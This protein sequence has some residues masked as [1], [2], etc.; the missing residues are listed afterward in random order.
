VAATSRTSAKPARLGSTEARVF[1]APAGELTRESSL[2]FEVVDFA[3]Q[4]LEIELYPWQ[5]WLLVHAL[6]LEDGHFRFRKIFVLIGRQNGKSTLLQILSLW[7]MYL[8]RAPLVLGT[9]QDRGIARDQWLGAVEIAQGVPDLAEEIIGDGPVTTRGFERFALKSGERY[10]IAA[11]NRRAGRGKSVDLLLMDELREHR[12]W[13]AWSAVS[14]TT[15]AR[16]DGQIWA[17]SS[18][19]DLS[20]VVLT[21]FRKQAH[22][23]LGDPDGITTNP[24]TGESMLPDLPDDV[25]DAAGALAIFEWSAAPGRGV[26]DRDG[27]AE[28]NP[29]MG[30]GALTERT[31]ASDA[32]SDPESVF[33]TE[34]LCQFVKTS[35]NGPFPAGAWEQTLLPTVARDKSR[36]AAY[37]IDVS[38][39]RTM[40]HIALAFWDADG[41]RRVEIVQSRPGPDWVIPWLQSPDR[42]V[43]PD[44]LT[45][46]TNGAPASS[47]VSELEAAGVTVAPWQGPDLARACGLFFDGI[48]KPLE[49][50]KNPEL[51]LTHGA[52]PILDVAANSARIK[53][54]GDGWAIDRKNSPED[55]APLMAAIGA[56]WL[57]TTAP[58]AFRSAYEDSDFEMV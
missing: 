31:I 19:G 15:N 57:L 4:V 9:A 52:Q 21:H 42:I 33:R 23:A 51:V 6:E 29:S 49:D 10:E 36:P 22:S 24:V 5:K 53:A 13:D 37:C 8:D 40:A 44:L 27:W 3:E 14:K 28:S 55:A 12:N 39:D 45:V 56:H 47:L 2:G 18:A 41:R 34:V 50:P 11:S 48:R 32:A 35:G 1:T 25:D 7:R 17:V 43:K 20:S 46:Q 38:H 26:W 54:L 30:Y 16:P 58:P